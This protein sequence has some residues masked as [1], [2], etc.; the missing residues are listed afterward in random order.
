MMDAHV[1]VINARLAPIDGLNQYCPQ[2][3]LNPSTAKN[4]IHNTT[5]PERT[6]SK[7]MVK[8]RGFPFMLKG[9]SELSRFGVARASRNFREKLYEFFF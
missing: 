3:S 2:I 4:K 8:L 1:D 7:T 9:L 5:M 6:L